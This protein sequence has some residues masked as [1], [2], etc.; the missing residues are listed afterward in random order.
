MR[1]VRAPHLAKPWIGS[2]PFYIWLVM[3]I[4]LAGLQ[5]GLPWAFYKPGAVQTQLIV[6]AIT[7]GMIELR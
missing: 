3:S 4:V 5:I 2:T 1:S 7:G 6:Q